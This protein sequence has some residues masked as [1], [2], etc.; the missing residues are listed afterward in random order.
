MDTVYYFKQFPRPIFYGG[1]Y[2]SGNF[3]VTNYPGGRFLCT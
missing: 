2:P 1:I 3:Q